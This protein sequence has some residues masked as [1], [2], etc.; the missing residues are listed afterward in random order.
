MTDRTASTRRA[1]RR[2]RV[3]SSAVVAAATVGVT[4]FTLSWAVGTTAPSTGSAAGSTT[5]VARQ[6]AAD[7]A[8]ITRLRRSIAV[9]DQQL[10][11]AAA[12]LVPRRGRWRGS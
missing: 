12:A 9:T 7:E 6:V 4:G 11:A 1:G 8:A 2:H 5:L 10:A 3:V